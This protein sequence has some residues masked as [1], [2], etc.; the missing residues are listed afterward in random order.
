MTLFS[1]K[2][3]IR[4]LFWFYFVSISAA[5]PYMGLYYRHIFNQLHEEHAIKLVTILLGIQPLLS[6]LSNPIA[7]YIADRFKIENRVL[8]F[9]SVLVVAGTLFLIFPG[10]GI[11]PIPSSTLFFIVCTLGIAITGL[12]GGPVFPVITTETLEHIHKNNEPEGSY[13]QYRAHASFSW[14]VFTFC[15]GSVLF[16]SQALV[17]VP[18]FYLAGHALIAFTARTGFQAKIQAAKVPLS[19]LFRDKSFFIFLIFCFIQSFSLFGSQ[20][21]ISI[22]FEDSRLNFIAMGIAFGISAIPEIPIML[23]AKKITAWLGNRKMIL[24]G[25]IIL[26]AKLVGL[27]LAAVY[28]QPWMIIVIMSIH[29]LGFGIQTLGMVNYIDLLSHPDL[30]ALYFNLY[31]VFGVN[32]PMALGLF[33]NG[34]ILELFDS[35]IMIFASAV[36]TA[37]AV[38]FF[39][40]FVRSPKKYASTE[41]LSE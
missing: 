10:T 25:T 8:F 4:L 39:I 38:L 26:T 18:V 33:F 29:G 15:I 37:V 34:A 31:T 7:G 13:G 3:R 9:C 23:N 35:Q 5:V 40:I 6:L 1:G 2:N 36:I 16:F 32:I 24:V 20:F 41:H 30:K 17:L 22:F 11:I 19:L 21:F 28:K 14:I 12:F 27:G